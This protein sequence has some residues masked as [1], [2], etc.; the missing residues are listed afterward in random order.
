[1]ITCNEK[2]FFFHCRTDRTVHSETYCTANNM[3][4]QQTSTLIYASLVFAY[5]NSLPHRPSS[6]CP[7]QRFL[8]MD[9]R[10]A[11]QTAAAGLALSRAAII[12]HGTRDLGVPSATAYS[13]YFCV[14]RV[15]S[16]F[17]ANCAFTRMRCPPIE[18]AQ[19]CPRTCDSVRAL[20]SVQYFWLK[21]CA[22][23]SSRLSI[24]KNK[25]IYPS[26]CYLVLLSALLLALPLQLPEP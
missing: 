9:N 11:S 16:K 3:G 15:Q 2:S 19:C 5:V 25:C 13:F 20:P 17:D 1:M 24:T 23:L 10:V 18:C 21:I 4:L 22:L 12:L 6:T 7:C 14:F 26:L 8:S